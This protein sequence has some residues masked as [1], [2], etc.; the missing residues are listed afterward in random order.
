MPALA[1]PDQS[2]IQLTAETLVLAIALAFVL[3]VV[4]DRVSDTV[5]GWRD[6][7]ERHR[8]AESPEVR[9]QREQVGRGRAIEDTFPEN[10]MRIT[11]L[12]EGNDAVA[13]WVEQLRVRIRITRSLTILAPALAT[14]GLLALLASAEPSGLLFGATLRS[15]LVVAPVLSLI[16]LLASFYHASAGALPSTRLEPKLAPSA[17]EGAASSEDHRASADAEAELQPKEATKLPARS[18]MLDPFVIW[19]LLHVVLAAAVLV[20][21]FRSTQV[22]PDATLWW[23]EAAGVALVGV[24]VTALAYHAW[25][26]ISRTYMKFLWE[27]CCSRTGA[28]L[29][30]AMT[31][32][33]ETETKEN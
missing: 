27:F 23:I 1:A 26:R 4:I 17:T 21:A 32:E 5:L 2:T 30:K 16:F 14:S 20:V 15:L 12:A 25:K 18:S 29:A 11:V 8:F 3:G 10:W 24:V 28:A 7:R 31:G 19:S 33:G 6:A 22:A 13:R 9:R